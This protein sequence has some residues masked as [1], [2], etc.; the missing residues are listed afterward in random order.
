M[1]GGYTHI[2]LRNSP[3]KRQCSAAGIVARGCAL[4][5]GVFQE[6][7]HRRVARTRL[8]LP[9]CHRQRF[10]RLGRRRAQG[11]RRGVPARRRGAGG[12]HCGR[13]RPPPLHG[14]VVRLRFPRRHGRHHPSGGQPQGWTLRAKQ[15]PSP[16][17]RDE[18]GCAQ[19]RA[20]QP[21]R[22][23]FQSADFL[24]RGRCVGCGGL[25]SFRSQ[26]GEAVERSPAGG[27]SGQAGTGHSRLASRHA[28]HDAVGGKRPRVVRVRP[29]RGG[30]SRLVYP[31]A[32]EDEYIHGLEVP[33][34]RM[35]FDELFA[36]AKNNV[37][38]LWGALA[39]SLQGRPSPLDDLKS[40]SLDTGIDE[41]GRMTYWS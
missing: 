35:D 1:S 8:S 5:F 14:V 30:Q 31:A 2:T 41:A 3:L 24:Q 28:S 21:G 33:G 13:Q 36:K 26:R 9:R 11:A 29:P 15:N 17:L 38:E 22:A 16:A 25:R 20:S 10:G 40:W 7:L 6:V 34:G 27:V 18:P 23:G 12:R 39:L 32:P 4:G 19:P 37:L